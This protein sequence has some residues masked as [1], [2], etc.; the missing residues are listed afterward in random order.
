MTSSKQQMSFGFANREENLLY[1]SSLNLVIQ[2]LLKDIEKLEHNKQ[3]NVNDFTRIIKVV[4]RSSNYRHLIVLSSWKDFLLFNMDR[5]K[6]NNLIEIEEALE[7]LDFKDPIL[8]AALTRRKDEIFSK[9]FF[10]RY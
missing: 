10:P 8:I 7:N 4:S 5:L 9:S 6:M 3:L 2:T 1:C